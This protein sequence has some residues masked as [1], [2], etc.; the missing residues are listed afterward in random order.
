MSAFG[1]VA[2]CIAISGARTSLICCVCHG[3]LNRASRART[4]RPVGGP[5]RPNEVPPPSP[6]GSGVAPLRELGKATTLSGAPGDAPEPP[7]VG[8]PPPREGATSLD[9]GRSLTSSA[10]ETQ[11]YLSS[12]RGYPDHPG[13]PPLQTVSRA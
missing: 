12:P 5:A 8:P 2:R 11:S 7:P 6:A 1:W 3:A 9:T 10:W 13:A 4:R